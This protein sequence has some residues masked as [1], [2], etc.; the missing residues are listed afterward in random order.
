LNLEIAFRAAGFG[1]YFLR[2]L[3]QANEDKVLEIFDRENET[4][5]QR[6]A[7]DPAGVSGH[8]YL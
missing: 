7:A 3:E 2:V 5:R 8:V 4:G 1:L 6:A